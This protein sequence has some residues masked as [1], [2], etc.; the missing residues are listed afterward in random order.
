MWGKKEKRAL[1]AVQQHSESVL[2]VV[3]KFE[4]LLSAVF[5]EFDFQKAE[6]LGRAV[7]ELESLADE[8]VR[9]FNKV[10]SQGAFLPAYRGDFARLGDQLDKVAD[11][12][13][14]VTRTILMRE[15]M[16]RAIKRAERRE[17]RIKEIREGLIKMGE[18]AVKS[19]DALNSSLKILAVNIDLAEIR[20]SE[21]GRIEHE[22]DLIEQDLLVGLYEL[23]K[24]L[25][26][27]TIVQLDNVI[28]GVGDI[29]DNAED[30]SHLVS[31][32]V[33]G[34]KL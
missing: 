6:S 28:H 13:E 16:L 9:N 18:L 23:E 29:S 26:P 10:L 17:R 1:A 12:T 21:V 11:I 19:V 20:A 3:K 2:G 24:F 7:S 33:Y 5:S 14:E 22:S 15:K 34:L 30:A 31:I 8:Q 27:V 4:E 25:D 32:I